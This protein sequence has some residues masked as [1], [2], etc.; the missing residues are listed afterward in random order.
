MMKNRIATLIPAALLA[1]S[2]AA[3]GQAATNTPAE[4]PAATSDPNAGVGEGGNN[5]EAGN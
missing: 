5:E 2:L 4:N 1:L 3:C